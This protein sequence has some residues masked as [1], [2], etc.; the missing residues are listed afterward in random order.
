L[1]Q[2]AL[3]RSL[4]AQTPVRPRAG[5]RWAVHA[6]ADE[7]ILELPGRRVTLPPGTADAVRAA[8][9]G[10]STP[11]ELPGLDDDG[12]LELVRQLLRE[13]VLVPGS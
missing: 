4:D 5:L 11:G 13:A 8:L 10:V 9:S 1:A 12:R 7:V 3:L 6:G 2:A